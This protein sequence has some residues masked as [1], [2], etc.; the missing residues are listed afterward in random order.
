VSIS[1]TFQV[2]FASQPGDDPYVWTTV[3]GTQDIEYSRGA[4][5]E[6]AQMETGESTVTVADADSDLDPNNAGST[7]YPN[8]KRGKA[9]RC[10]LTVDGTDYPAFQ[11]FID[12]LPRAVALTNWTQRTI[13]G[14]DAFG[15]FALAR[16]DA[17]GAGFPSE[18]SGARWGRV[19]DAIGWAAS[20]R[21]IDTGSSNLDAYTNDSDTEEKALPHLLS[22][23]ESENGLG[24]MDAVGNARFIERH[25]FILNTTVAAVLA[26]GVSIATGSYPTAIP[27]Q[28]LQPESTDIFNQYTGKRTASGSTVLTNEDATSVADYG[29]RSKDVTLLVD[30]DNEVQDAIDWKLSQTKDPFERVDGITVMPGND[31]A[32]WATVLGLEVGDRI[33][34]V[35]QPAGYAAPVESQYIIRH[36]DVKLPVA[37][38]ASE[39]TFQLTPVTRDAWFVLDDATAGQLDA[40]KLAY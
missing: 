4:P 37:L 31:P 5:N 35:E 28:D 40:N 17:T 33:L 34:V 22:V 36:L 23:V 38:S 20:R 12:R 19:L 30:S 24:F 16:L 10:F 3:G 14:V 26:D 8:V 11:H 1:L 29:P 6:Y 32:R 13:K 27:Y 25:S 21:D 15:G 18:S 2:A 7:H 39:F 9:I